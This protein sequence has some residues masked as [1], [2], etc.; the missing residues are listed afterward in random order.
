MPGERGT[1][2]GD[3]TKNY[4]DQ[5][6]G[7]CGEGIA[8]TPGE[9]PHPF[10]GNIMQT[11]TAPRKLDEHTASIERVL[12]HIVAHRQRTLGRE[13]SHRGATWNNKIR[14][15]LTGADGKGGP[16]TADQ[17]CDV[18]DF[19]TQ[20]DFW[21]GIVQEPVGLAKHAHKI[22]LKDDYVRWAVN[23]KRPQ[24]NRP[25]SVFRVRGLPPGVLVTDEPRNYPAW[26]PFFSS[27]LVTDGLEVW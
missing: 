5:G 1:R 13:H 2:K 17:I 26:K 8:D 9:N 3:P 23:S 6:R 12:R 27:R 15:L 20:D 25:H 19:C 14:V 18:F 16:L 7:K 22:F 21:C 24:Q 10:G 11:K 4:L